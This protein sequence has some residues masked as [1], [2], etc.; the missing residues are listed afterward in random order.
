M[1]N[2]VKLRIVFPIL[3]LIAVTVVPHSAF[4]QAVYGSIFGTVTDPSGAGVPNAKVTLTD[5]NKNTKFEVETNTDGNYSRT[6]LI[7]GTYNVEVEATGFTKA[8]NK[9]VVV[10]ADTAARVD[11]RME[12]GNVATE[13]EVVA[14]AAMLKSDRSDVSTIFN[15]KALND[16]PSFSRN[17][18]AH[19]L[20]IPGTQKLGWQHASSENPQGSL[21]IEVNG[22]H[23]SGTGFQLD[24]TDNQDPILGIIVI[25]PTL[26]SVTESKFTTQNYDAEFGLAIAGVVTAQTKSG[27][28]DIH[29]SAFEYVRDNTP[30]FTTF[31]RNPF[32]S[33]EDKQVPP[34]KWNQFGGSIGG[35]IKKN[36]IFYFGDVQITRRRTGASVLTQVPTLKA[37][38]GDFS[39]YLEPIAGAP[40][41]RTTEGNMVPFQRNMIFD[42]LTG[43][44]TGQN[45]QAFQSGGVLNKI[46][47]SRL[48]PQSLNLLKFIPNPN[49]VD[50]SGSAF[51]RNY[52]A[53]G[54]ENFDTNQW[55]TRID[56]FASEKVQLFGRYSWANF[57][58]SAPGAFGLLPGGAA[59]DTINFA[60]VSDVRNQSL[61]T[62]VNYVF[63]PSLLSEFRFGFMRYRVNVLPNGLGTSPA[64]DAGIPGLN[65]DNFFT[66]GMPG[67]FINGD[68][69]FNFGYALGTNQC[70]CP[71][72]QQEQQFQFVNNTSKTIR[73]HNVK[74]GADIRYAMNLRVPSDAHRAGELTFDN[75]FTGLVQGADTS[76]GLGLATFLLGEVTHM[77]RYVSPTTDAAER[78]K[79]FFW[80]IQD[81]WRATAKLTLNYGLRW[82]QIFP[83]KVNGAGKGGALDLSTGDIAVYGVGGVSDHGIVDMNWKNFAP[84]LGI[85]YQVTPKTVVRA[86][87]GWSYALGTFGSIFG[88]NV[89]QNLPV[90]AI[91]DVSRPNDFSGVFTLAQGP[92]PPEFPKPGSNGRFRLPDGVSGKARPDPLRLPRVEAYNVTVQHQLTESVTVEAGYVGNVGRHSFTGDGPSFNVNA[93][94]F[95]PGVADSNI[96]KP[97]FQ[98][99]GW[100]Q[101]IDFYCNCATTK[102]DSLQTK[103]E[104]RF[105][106]GYG[107]IGHYTLSR[108][109]QDHDDGYSFLY[110][111]P[112]G[113]GVNDFDRTHVFVVAQNFDVPFG[114]GRAFGN[115]MGKP[116]DVILGGWSLNAITT[117]YSGLPFNPSFDNPDPSKFVRPNA[118]PG[119][120]PDRGT[121]DPYAPDRGRNQWIA[122]GLGGPFL[123]PANN[124]FGNY[125]VNQLRG[126]RLFQQDLSVFKNFKPTER[127]EIQI[128]AEAF[129]VFNHTNLGMPNS[130]VTSSDAGK[131]NGL[132]AAGG[133][134]AL[135]L[136]RRMQFGFRFVF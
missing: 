56:Y 86:G 69:G 54:S 98:R 19:E 21:Q 129:N 135:G 64:K 128:R 8:V 131:I 71:L 41:V 14:E 99:Y 119:S 30:G 90:L 46:P 48:S 123:V 120:R 82:E 55:D 33:A 78:Q 15:Q 134:D 96:R 38:Q 58:K 112:L 1:P 59:L 106:H 44:A 66:S 29:G 88:H 50:R 60:G 127:T 17:F 73:N 74:F 52:A 11:V 121:S 32:N 23:F 83:E 62:G 110:N 10:S 36:K 113:R 65:L 37:R 24:G 91:Q 39:E 28:N 75:G 87:Y 81:T 80:Y 108:G 126:P 105:S 25:N 109:V 102:Y 16:L 2:S 9:N 116:V 61:A 104:K 70:N 26:E 45:R 103:I 40:M 34:V 97:F 84:R 132:A 27:T 72:D 12:V 100:S 22:Q 3:V 13:V 107:V 31:A 18:Q 68:G 114:R 53:T 57:N 118:G 5:V 101:G 125:G 136:M 67:V 77:R 51:R 63:N 93:P 124:A 79:R 95:V 133:E 43:D 49:A 117:V 76:Q 92:N 4:A 122:K 94:A 85:A 89:T 20:L 115:Q 130:N 111:R 35:A 47:V 7:P 42:P 6:Q